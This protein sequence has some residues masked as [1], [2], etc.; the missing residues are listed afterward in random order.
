MVRLCLIGAAESGSTV[1]A[2][3]TLT[4]IHPRLVAKME[5]SL[6][7][8]GRLEAQFHHDRAQLERQLAHDAEQRTF[9]RTAHLLADGC[10]GLAVLNS[11][12]ALAMLAF[13]G[14]L[15]QKTP[16]QIGQFKSYGLTALALFLAGALFASVAFIPHYQQT[17]FEHYKLAAKATTARLQLGGLILVSLAAFAIGASVAA[18]GIAR[19]F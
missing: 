10:K 5:D 7:A 15:A 3:A 11:G 18:C 9:E 1:V 17:I 13:F 19:C 16:I 14:S 6:A 2:S 4:V 8:S 12:A